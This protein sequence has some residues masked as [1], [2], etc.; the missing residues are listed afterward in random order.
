[1]P[2]CLLG[3]SS[4]VHPW[5]STYLY[6]L[7]IHVDHVKGKKALL[8]INPSIIPK[9]ILGLVLAAMRVLHVTHSSLMIFR[10][11][12][13]LI[14]LVDFWL[15]HLL[16]QLILLCFLLQLELH[17]LRFLV[18]IIIFK[19]STHL[20][21]SCPWCFLWKCRVQL[22]AY[23]FTFVFVLFL[24][25]SSE[26]LL[27]LH[28]LLEQLVVLLAESLWGETFFPCRCLLATEMGD[29]LLGLLLHLGN[30]VFKL[31]NC[32][33]RTLSLHFLQDATRKFN[34]IHALVIAIVGRSDEMVANVGSP[35][36]L[37][38]LGGRI[39]RM[40]WRTLGKA[41]D[42][43]GGGCPPMCWGVARLIT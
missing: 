28:F 38:S 10:I 20:S 34:N 6:E 43:G 29:T 14:I 33:H 36:P 39:C 2:P 4:H 22:L 7:L 15:K 35:L 26:F 11:V 18:L 27:R 16:E 24:N 25:H 12:W 23:L 30:L 31:S 1:M 3:R 17:L 8:L 9:L 40:D 32:G 21:L 37:R 41:C 13:R 19:P 42:L 5:L